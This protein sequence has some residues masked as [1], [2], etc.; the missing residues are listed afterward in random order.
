MDISKIIYYTRDHESG[1]SK[2]ISLRE[3]CIREEFEL[4]AVFAAVKDALDEQDL[5]D[6]LKRISCDQISIDTTS[7]DYIRFEVIDVSGNTN[8]LKFKKRRTI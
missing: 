5:L 1:K 3:L 6:R 7:A 4:E 2:T 8:Y